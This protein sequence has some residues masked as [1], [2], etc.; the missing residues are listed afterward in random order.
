MMKSLPWESPSYYFHLH[1]ITVGLYTISMVL[2]SVVTI[3]ED[4]CRIYRGYIALPITVSLS[5]WL[6]V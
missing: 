3:T 5:N 6:S 1:C 2:P 4:F